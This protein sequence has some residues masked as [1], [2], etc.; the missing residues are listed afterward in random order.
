MVRSR[1]G[2]SRGPPVSGKR[3]S[4]RVSNAASGRWAMR[5]A[6]SSMANG[7]PSSLRQIAVTAAALVSV[8]SKSGL[9]AC[10]RAT[11][12]RV[13]AAASTSSTDG[14]ACPGGAQRGDREIVLGRNVE[15]GSARTSSLSRGLVANHSAR[16]CGVEHLLRSCRA[17]ATAGG[18]GASR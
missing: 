10:A 17:A 6:A 2:W 7:S 1:S 9:V 5:A 3:S 8:S 18:N 15:Y 11:N 12:N 4:N 16:W 14:W 13:A